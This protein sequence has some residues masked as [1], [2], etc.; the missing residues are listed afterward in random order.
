MQVPKDSWTESRLGKAEMATSGSIVN[1]VVTRG[2][3]GYGVL[4]LHCIR[5]ESGG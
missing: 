4:I 2:V 3:R 1:R 5:A